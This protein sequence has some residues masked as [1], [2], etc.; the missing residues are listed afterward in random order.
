MS[1]PIS[2][3][4]VFNPNTFTIDQIWSIYARFVLPKPCS[5]VQH[6]EMKKAFYAGFLDCF[7][8][9]I[10]FSE[11]LSEEE[12]CVLFERL[13]KEGAN[14]FDLMVKEHGPV[15]GQHVDR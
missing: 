3:H 11:G 12:S 7:K 1:R 8:V 13:S 4:E 5:Q 14:F 9:M 15:N 2:Y 10:D 6:D